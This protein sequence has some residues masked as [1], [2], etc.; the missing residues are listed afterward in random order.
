MDLLPREWQ[1]SEG[2]G[3]VVVFAKVE[4]LEEVLPFCQ[5][6]VTDQC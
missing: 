6:D 5:P 1:N 4:D 3:V 2:D